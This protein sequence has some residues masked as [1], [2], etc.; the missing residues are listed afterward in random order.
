MKKY[1]ITHFIIIYVISNIIYE[2]T[3]FSLQLEIEAKRTFSNTI[4]NPS[5]SIRISQNKTEQLRRNQKKRE[6]CRTKKKQKRMKKDSMKN[7]KEEKRTKPKTNAL[8]TKKQDPL[9]ILFFKEKEP[10]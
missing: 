8:N 5:E 1:D 3:Q 10:E 4:S 7:T 6:H 2:I 9:Q